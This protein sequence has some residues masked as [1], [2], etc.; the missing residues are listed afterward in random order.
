MRGMRSLITAVAVGFLLAACA[1]AIADPQIVM[2][3]MV[4]S[5]ASHVKL[6]GCVETHLDDEPQ[7]GLQANWTTSVALTA[8]K[9]R[10]ETQDA[11][12][13]VLQTDDL[14]PTGTFAV[15]EPQ[16]GAWTV[17]D[18]HMP[19]RANIAKVRCAIVGTIDA[20]GKTWIAPTP[21]PK[22][23]SK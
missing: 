20:T 3:S 18:A 15:G 16:V 14:A 4:S 2:G 6:T 19:A 21:A 12:G 11:F 23:S 13:V 9:I 17:G 7:W 1:P 10:F 5:A 22:A 8:I